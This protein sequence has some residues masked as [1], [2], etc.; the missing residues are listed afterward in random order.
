MLQHG[1]TSVWERW[2]W[3]TSKE[4]NSH[5]HP[6]HGSISA[7]FFNTLAGIRPTHEHPGFKHILLKPCLSCGLTTAGGTLQSP[8][9]PIAYNWEKTDS[10]VRIH[11]SVPENST[12]ELI[13]PNG[14]LR[15]SRSA[16][17]SGLLCG[18]DPFEGLL[19]QQTDQGLRVV[20]GSG[21]YV[22]TFQPTP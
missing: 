13:L 5:D 1:A 21:D 18:V 17:Q 19:E 6:M 7:W 15:E 3:E 11:V 2:E 10:N 4:M 8:Y 16:E 14:L 22:F 20:F 9:G 12:A